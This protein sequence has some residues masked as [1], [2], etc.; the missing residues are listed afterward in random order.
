M[1]LLHRLRANI[2]LLGLLKPMNSQEKWLNVEPNKKR[3]CMRYQDKF[4]VKG[5]KV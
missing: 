2:V 5:C 4:T 3:I 1:V